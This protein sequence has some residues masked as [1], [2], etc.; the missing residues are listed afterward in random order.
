MANEHKP[1]CNNEYF[2]SRHK[3]IEQRTNKRQMKLY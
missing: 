1:F 3:T 2:A